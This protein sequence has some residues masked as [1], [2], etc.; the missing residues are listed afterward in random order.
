MK[1]E[2]NTL[3]DLTDEQVES[4]VLA[5][6]GCII[7]DTPDKAEYNFTTESSA[8]GYDVWVIYDKKYNIYE[9][10][11]EGLFYQ[12]GMEWTEKIKEFIKDGYSIYLADRSWFGADE[13][14]ELAEE[15]G[16]MDKA[17][18]EAF[19]VGNNAG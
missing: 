4:L 16:Y 6:T 12:E 9:G 15:E 18:E 2:W 5:Q 13:F 19:G 8:D 14:R 7:Y 11:G 3:E 17:N 10:I 1:N